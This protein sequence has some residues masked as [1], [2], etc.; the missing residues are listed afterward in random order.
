MQVCPYTVSTW[1]GKPCLLFRACRYSSG[2]IRRGLCGLWRCCLHLTILHYCRFFRLK[3][4]RDMH[5]GGHD[6][7]VLKELRTAPDLVPRATKFMAWSLGRTMSTL[8]F[9]VTY[10]TLVPWRRERRRHVPSPWLLYHH[11]VAGSRLGSS[12]KTWICTTP[13]AY[14]YSRCDQWQLDAL[15]AWQCALAR[16]IYTRNRLV[17]LDPIRRSSDVTSPFP[18]S[19]NECLNLFGFMLSNANIFRRSKHTCLSSSPIVVTVKPSA[20]YTSSYFLVLAF[21]RLTF[22]S[23]SPSLSAF[24][25]IPV[26]YFSMV[27]LKGLLSALHISCS[28]LCALVRCKK[29]LLPAAKKS[30]FAGVT[31][32]SRDKHTQ[33]LYIM[34]LL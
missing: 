15:I 3:A 1:Q 28:V 16:L 9:S 26:K 27:S 32:K 19:G 8:V 17:S 23:L 6:P 14:L 18:P 13:A 5:G 4:L 34:T 33:H 30:M 20:I 29:K 31:R 10:V 24:L 22:V 25:F 12:A 11:W 2:L 21:G 7:E